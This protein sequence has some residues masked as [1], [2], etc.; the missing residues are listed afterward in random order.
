VAALIDHGEVAAVTFFYLAVFNASLFVAN[1]RT[2]P[3]A[4]RSSHRMIPK[5]VARP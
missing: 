5:G 2:A 3:H 4:L 1:L